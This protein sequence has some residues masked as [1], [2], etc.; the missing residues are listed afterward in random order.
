MSARGDVSQL[1]PTSPSQ[2][3]GVALFYATAKCRHEQGL[4][5]EL[6]NS[7]YSFGSQG[8]PF[9]HWV[10]NQIWVWER[11]RIAY[12][13][14]QKAASRTLLRLLPQ[15]LGGKHTG[16]YRAWGYYEALPNASKGRRLSSAHMLPHEILT[17]LENYTLIT[18]VRNPLSALV[19]GY[20]EVVLRES[21]SLSLC[22]KK[23]LAATPQ[24]RTQLP[25]VTASEA[26]AAKKRCMLQSFGRNASASP[27]YMQTPCNVTSLHFEAFLRDLR[28]AGTRIGGMGYHAWPQV[29]KVDVIPEPCRNFD[30]IGRVEHLIEDLGSLFQWLNSTRSN[31]SLPMVPWNIELNSKKQKQDEFNKIDRSCGSG[32]LDYTPRWT[33]DLCQLLRADLICFGY[34]LPTECADPAASS[35]KK[36]R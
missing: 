34:D 15:V 13:E 30:F 26:S 33:P 18:F 10:R 11:Q 19:S 3:R 5:Q 12:V 27:T 24:Q 21:R 28:T 31:Y 6:F 7:V 8:A 35:E 2:P 32:M 4:H 14:N 23:S 17:R 9:Y 22:I 20:H 1:L 25:P 29:I 16:L 36:G